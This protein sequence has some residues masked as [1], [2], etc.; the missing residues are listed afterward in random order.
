MTLQTILNKQQHK[1]VAKKH[2]NTTKVFSGYL[3]KAAADDFEKFLNQ[4]DPGHLCVVDYDQRLDNHTIITKNDDGK[5]YLH[6]H[7]KAFGKPISAKDV[8][9]FLSQKSVILYH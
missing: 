5:L 6:G 2:L 7:N 1:K 4:C 9:L 3:L 8:G